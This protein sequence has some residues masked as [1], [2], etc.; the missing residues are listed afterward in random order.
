MKKRVK[1]FGVFDGY[2]GKFNSESV[3]NIF[4]KVTDG[5]EAIYIH[6]GEWIKDKL[7]PLKIG[8]MS[9]FSV[10]NSSAYADVE[11]NEKGEQLYNDKIIKGISV[12]LDSTATKLLSVA[13]LP[14]GVN[15]AIKD[16][17]IFQESNVVNFEEMIQNNIEGGKRMTIDEVVIFLATLTEVQLKEFMMKLDKKQAK[18]IAENVIEN[19]DIGTK[20]EMISCIKENITEEEK[21]MARTIAYEFSEYVKEPEK[22]QSKAEIRAET[23]ME[24]EAEKK[25]ESEKRMFQEVIS[26]KVL[27]AHREAYRLAFEAVQS[28]SGIIEFSQ[29]VKCTKKDYLKSIVEKMGDIDLTVEFAQVK[30]AVTMTEDEKAVAEIKAIKEET[31]KRNGGK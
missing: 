18:E 29:D 7:E 19:G 17:L 13:F 27:P 15:P 16:A 9:N 2:Q 30:P 12:E 10:E 14:R 11:F 8:L 6:S 26:K 1:V 5:I 24:F 20:L 25:A 28:E 22:V 3:S 31:K 21:A 4:S 23:L